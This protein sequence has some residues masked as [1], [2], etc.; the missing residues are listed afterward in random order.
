MTTFITSSQTPAD[1]LVPMQNMLEASKTLPFSIWANVFAFTDLTSIVKLGY[2]CQSLRSCVYSNHRLI[3][4]IRCC[5]F[6]TITKTTF[7]TSFKGY[8]EEA[9]YEAILKKSLEQCTKTNTISHSIQGPVFKNALTI[10][11]TFPQRQTV[12]I[13]YFNHDWHIYTQTHLLTVHSSHPA[14]YP[15]PFLHTPNF[16][17]QFDES[18]NQL[19]LTDGSS[20]TPLPLKITSE[21]IRGIE[22]FGSSLLGI[23]TLNQVHVIDLTTM[24]PMTIFSPFMLGDVHFLNEKEILLIPAS[25]NESARS[26]ADIDRIKQ[27]HRSTVEVLTAWDLEKNTCTKRF[28][29]P[30]QER[31]YFANLDSFKILNYD[32][33]VITAAIDSTIGVKLR[34]F[35]WDSSSPSVPLINQTV[36]ISQLSITSVSWMKVHHGML[37]IGMCCCTLSASKQSAAIVR[38]FKAS[39]LHTNST[40]TE[41]SQNTLFSTSSFAHDIGMIFV[42]DQLVTAHVEDQTT[43]LSFYDLVSNP[44]NS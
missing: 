7:F 26:F 17:V 2:C 22:Y 41:V 44:K 30:T 40:L 23:V 9:R 3:L 39:D 43:K 24:K 34:I 6:S 1:A 28:L 16:S 12:R 20:T 5:F 13:A 15:H 25:I 37:W 42:E 27:V 19:N 29:T 4:K 18:G 35:V 36:R 10:P 38:R 31:L 14:I 21:Q 32:R 33:F 8:L 11:H